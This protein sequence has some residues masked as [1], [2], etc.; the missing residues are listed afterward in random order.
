MTV[1]YTTSVVIECAVDS[2]SP[3]DAPE[4]FTGRP[5]EAPVLVIGNSGPLVPEESGDEK[6]AEGAREDVGKT[7]PLVLEE[8]RPADTGDE[9]GKTAP[10][11]LE[12]DRPADGEEVEVIVGK[13]DIVGVVAVH[14]WQ[15]VW[16][17]VT[18]TVDTSVTTTT[19][20]V[21]PDLMVLVT[22]QDVTVV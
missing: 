10:L 1:S 2:K 12:E 18:R 7:A 9:L 5:E 17:S 15:M 21:V 19:A 4:D 8:E 6:P 3:L 20:C 16:V 22:G 13:L 11:V 14:L